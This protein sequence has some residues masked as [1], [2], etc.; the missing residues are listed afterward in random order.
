[1]CRPAPA[2]RLA[3]TPHHAF[4]FWA[5]LKRNE[6]HPCWRRVAQPGPGGGRCPARHGK[7]EQALVR[8]LL[9]SSE[10]PWHGP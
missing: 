9:R 8:V 4:R 7:K 10:W 5:A 1:M 6:A 3:G 2:T